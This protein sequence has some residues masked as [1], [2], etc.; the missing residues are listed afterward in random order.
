MCLEFQLSLAPR[1]MMFGERGS[2]RP[3]CIAGLPHDPAFTWFMWT[4]RDS[5]MV[6]LQLSEI[7]SQQEGRRRVGLITINIRRNYMW[8]R[9]VILVQSFVAPPGPMHN[10][11]SITCSSIQNSSL[12]PHP[13]EKKK[14]MRLIIFFLFQPKCMLR[15]GGND[16]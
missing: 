10:H 1:L 5:L 7:E 9:C 2:S 11:T 12:I 4:N 16:R 13:F 6:T 8:C 15:L 3:G 14:G